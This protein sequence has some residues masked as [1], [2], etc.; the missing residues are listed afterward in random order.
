M[1]ATLIPT[2]V[3]KAAHAGSRECREKSSPP[4]KARPVPSI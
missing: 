3:E 4:A 2:V 1:A